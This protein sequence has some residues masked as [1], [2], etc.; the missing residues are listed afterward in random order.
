MVS[1]G[2]VVSGEASE[3]DEDE[4]LPTSKSPVGLLPLRGWCF[5]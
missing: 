5:I 2:V 3:S 4:E 1:S